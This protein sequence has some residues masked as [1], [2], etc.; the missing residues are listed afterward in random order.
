MIP[1]FSSPF[2]I[3]SV[4]SEWLLISFLVLVGIIYWTISKKIGFQALYLTIFSLSLGYIITM[5]L[6]YLYTNDQ[7]LPLTHPHIQAVM[8][9]FSIFIP[10]VRR[11]VEIIMCLIPPLF[12]SVI[13][14]LLQGT[15]VFSIVG[16]ILIGGFISYMYY[17]S[18]DWIEAMP[19]RYVFGFAIIVPIFI[20]ILIY[21]QNDFLILPGLLLGSGIGIALEQY[22]L[23]ISITTSSGM[24]KLIALMIGSSGL[25]LS[26]LFFL[27]NP[28][29][30]TLYYSLL[31]FLAGLWITFLIPLLLF[32]TKLYGQQSKRGDTA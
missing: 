20:G 10:L 22:K 4:W 7:L 12:I 6:P 8:T 29:I 2:L 5:Y 25:I 18:F 28:V 21:P 1:P 30:F 14:L 16:G 26:H 17:R 9:L 15:P 13:Y 24:S 31:G 32:S 27:F 19:E 11:Q 3:H 23:R